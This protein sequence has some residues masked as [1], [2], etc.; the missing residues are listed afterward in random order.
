M[1]PSILLSDLV[2]AARKTAYFESMSVARFIL[3]TN[4]LLQCRD[5][6][7]LPWKD[8]TDAEEVELYPAPTA[9]HE[10]D[11]FKTSGDRRADRARQVSA[12]MRSVVLNANE[13]LVLRPHSPLLTL[14]M[15]PPLEEVTE[16]KIAQQSSQD[17]R[18]VEEACALAKVLPDL[19]LLSADTGPSLRAKQRG[20]AFKLVG[21]G[22]LLPPSADPK[23]RRIT[24]LEQQ[25]AA[26]TKGGP[27]IEAKLG[28]IG[29]GDAL[30]LPIMEFRQIS[31]KVRD[32]LLEQLTGEVLSEAEERLQDRLRGRDE[33]LV[34]IPTYAP[35]DYLADV[36]AWREK[37]SEALDHS[38][39]HAQ[40]ASR[41]YPF[42][43][44]VTNT[45]TKPAEHVKV[46]IVASGCVILASAA[47]SGDYWDADRDYLAD[48]RLVRLA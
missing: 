10:I 14:M 33:S 29:A 47:A 26:L 27:A 4:L 36:R 44:F 38:S 12:R 7:E 24:A 25:I 13:R 37:V 11:K 22:W 6:P 32:E 34:I 9:L 23:D 43:L 48:A 5:L 39:P 3:D 19:C 8:V 31:P 35:E 46:Q 30:A 20:M 40:I 17:Y 16:A 2:P 42:Q 28:V 1:T 45:G 21:E 41:L 18:I 15:P